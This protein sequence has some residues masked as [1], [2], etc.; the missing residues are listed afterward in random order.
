M[1]VLAT[2]DGSAFSE[3]TL[4]VLAQMTALPGAELTLLRIDE[5]PEERVRRGRRVPMS[6][7][8]ALGP[9]A[10]MTFPPGEPEFVETKDQAVDRRLAEIEEYLS[11][12][13]AKL[14]TDASVHL[15]AHVSDDA[16]ATIIERARAE[17]P[18][19]VVM[20]TH[21]KRGLKSLFGSTTE[22]VVR[23]GVAPV[24]LVHPVE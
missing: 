23:S 6:S 10:A 8:A 21:S 2:F 5:A 4:P 14:P 7:G 15:E 22:Q 9:M 16:A 3:A 17:Q 1:K 24:L 13:A 12:I 18:D 20:A 19:V 11:G